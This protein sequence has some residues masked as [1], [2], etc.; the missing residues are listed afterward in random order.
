MRS[1]IDLLLHSVSDVGYLNDPYGLWVANANFPEF[2]VVCPRWMQGW[3]DCSLRKFDPLLQLIDHFLFWILVPKLIV[4][5]DSPA[6]DHHWLICRVSI[7]G[8][9]LCLLEIEREIDSRA[10]SSQ[11]W[12]LEALI[13][14]EVGELSLCSMVNNLTFRT[15]SSEMV[16]IPILANSAEMFGMH[17]RAVCYLAIH[18]DKKY[19]L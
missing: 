6:C 18:A 4:L 7:K 3:F 8:Y 15:V 11:S 9:L 16:R 17:F 1:E 14:D 5:D 2:L 13:L 12:R 19:R 10:Y